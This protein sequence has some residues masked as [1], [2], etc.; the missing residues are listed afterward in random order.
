MT[1]STTA[2]IILAAGSSVRFGAP[3]MLHPMSNGQP[4]LLSTINLY[5]KVFERVHVVTQ[6]EDLAL[7]D[8]VASSGAIL[9]DSPNAKLGMSASLIAGVTALADEQR[10]LIALGDMPYIKSSTLLSIASSDGDIVLPR[11]QQQ[12]GNPVSFDQRF[13]QS[14]L[15][16]SGDRGAKAVV[17]ANWD[18]VS[19][20]DVDDPGVLHDIDVPEAI[21]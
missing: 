21:I 20:I 18:Q 17:R 2:C 10:C 16:L 14:L 11:H 8:L 5:Q 3:K 15:S 9:I 6:N 7:R 19:I 4:M 1:K 12:V 13:R